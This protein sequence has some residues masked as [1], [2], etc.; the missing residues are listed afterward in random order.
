MSISHPHSTIHH[1]DFNLPWCQAI[2]RDPSIDVSSE[3]P[4]RF[5]DKT[6]SNSMFRETLYTDRGIRA[7]LSLKRPCTEPDA[8]MG[9]E[10]C[11]VLSVGP[12]ID[13]KTGR[14]HG[15]FNSLVL[16]Q[17]SGSCAHWAKPDPIPP[18][19]ATM[20]VD[21]KAPVETPCVLLSRA[22]IC[23]VSGRKV[24]VKAVL[25]DGQGHVYATSRALFITAKPEQQPKL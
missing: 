2:L 18:A 8:V 5:Q 4:K 22:W 9:E 11:F 23:E 19:T 20:T 1:P 6:V 16:D 15:G 12:A 24:W 10:N 7:H 17:I 14:A 3:T 21:F 25:E 13:G